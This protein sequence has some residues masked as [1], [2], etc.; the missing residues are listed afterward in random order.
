MSDSRLAAL[1][2]NDSSIA[3]I[4]S[5][6][7]TGTKIDGRFVP[8][9]PS[10]HIVS[11]L[12]EHIDSEYGIEHE[13]YLELVE[14]RLVGKLLWYSHLLYVGVL[15][16]RLTHGITFKL[17]S[18]LWAVDESRAGQSYLFP[19]GIYE[20]SFIAN[21]PYSIPIRDATPSNADQPLSSYQSLLFSVFFKLIYFRC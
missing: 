17:M 9:R 12:I 16:M 15:T 21:A 14:F 4:S 7:R 6:T 18:P 11:W 5:S 13:A 20:T 8:C 2:I 3:A 10:K 19:H 1:T